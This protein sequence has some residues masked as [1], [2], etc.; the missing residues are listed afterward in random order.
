MKNFLSYVGKNNPDI[1]RALAG[2]APGTTAFNNAWK[3]LANNNSA[4]FQS[5]QHEFIKSTHYTPALNSI[6]KSTGIDVS[7]RGP[8]VQEALWSTSIQHGSGGANNVFKN[9][10]ISNNMSDAEII[11][12]VYAE[13]GANN[14]Q[15]YFPSSSQ[16]IRTS[17][18]NRF[19]KEL[20]DVLAMI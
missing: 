20:N 2:K 17:V 13:R 3:S 8:A 7:K 16:S 6:K 18:V 12:R 1:A 15:K 4:A 11:R 9:A 5:A 10:G 19:K 14:G